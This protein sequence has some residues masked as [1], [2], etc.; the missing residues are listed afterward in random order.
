MEDTILAT[1]TN[2]SSGSIANMTFDIEDWDLLSASDKAIITNVANA[3]N[4]Q[5]HHETEG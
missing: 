3:N 4:F 5:F 2:Y 1:G